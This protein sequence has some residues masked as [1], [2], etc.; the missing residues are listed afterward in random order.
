MLNLSE[1]SNAIITPHHKEFETLLKN[2]GYSKLNNIKDMGKKVKELS[3][4]K[5][6]GNNVI[7]LK[8]ETDYVLSSRKI[9]CNKTG[10]PGMTKAGTGDVLAGLCTGFLAQDKKRN[11]LQA[12]INATYYNGSIGD[13]LLKKKK[14]FN[15]LASDMVEEIERAIRKGF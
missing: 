11:L 2:S 9:L 6:I 7:I 10:N 1:I 3:Q 14:G 4:G 8:G 13:I 5:Y 12:A 15:F